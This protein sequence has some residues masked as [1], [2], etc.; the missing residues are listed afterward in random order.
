MTSGINVVD[1]NTDLHITS[2]DARVDITRNMSYISN[3]VKNKLEHPECLHSED[4][5]AAPWLPMLLTRSYW[6]P[7]QNNTKSKLQISRIFQNFCYT[8]GQREMLLTHF[9]SKSLLI[10]H[11]FLT[12]FLI[13]WWLPCQPSK[14]H[15]SYMGF[16]RESDVCNA[17]A[18]GY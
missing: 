13:G 1:Y 3:D 18:G 10:N 4:T 5:P 17:M 2:I 8:W 6:I 11:H 7:S 15:S 14:S 9:P 12:W 16:N